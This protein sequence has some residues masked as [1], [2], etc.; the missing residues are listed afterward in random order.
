MKKN[1]PVIEVPAS[2][3]RTIAFVYSKTGNFV[4]KGFRKEVV[5]FLR[6]NYKDWVAKFTLWHNGQY[7]TI[8]EYWKKDISF[9]VERNDKNRRREKNVGR[10][11]VAIVKYLPGRYS[12]SERKNLSF[13]RIPN[14]WIPEYDMI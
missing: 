6:Q 7:R 5:E 8:W 4:V 13:K 9:F 10:F 14:K 2:G 12:S 11:T 1:L 3:A